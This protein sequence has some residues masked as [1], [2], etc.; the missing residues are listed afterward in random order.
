MLTLGQVV[1][2]G[3]LLGGIYALASVGL[4]LVFGVMRIINFA[5]GEFLMLGMY[6]AFW[7]FALW[8]VDPYAASLGL[9]ALGVLLGLAVGRLVVL[10]T[11]GRPHVVQ[12][13]ATVGLS[14]ALQ[15]LVL[16]LWTGNYRTIRTAYTGLTLALGPFRISV[17]QLLGFVIAVAVALAL[18][19]V[20]HRTML[21]RAIRA[22]AQDRLAATL[23][24]IDVG[25]I[26]LWAFALATACV[27]IAGALLLPL[28]PAFP[29]VGHKYVLIAFVVVILGGMGSIKGALAGG[30]LL[31]VVESLSGYLLGAAMKELVYFVLV[32]TVLAL[33]PSGLFGLREPEGASA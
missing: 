2:S 20:L 19:G 22:T 9:V 21:G 5:H 15:N 17:A 18:I 3:L 27:T 14:L 28:Y 30:L 24:G 10:P 1:I 29:T 11:V 23:V 6:G 12:V 33:R 7:A 13:F 16:Y 26:Y 31:G 25:R 4:S 32:I 8:G